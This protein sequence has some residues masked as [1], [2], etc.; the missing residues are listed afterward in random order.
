LRGFVTATL[1]VFSALLTFRP[2]VVL[3]VIAGFLVYDTVDC[4]R[5]M[6]AIGFRV[7]LFMV[8]AF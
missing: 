8:S 4:T 5:F 3:T 2:L 7:S 6:V 1:G